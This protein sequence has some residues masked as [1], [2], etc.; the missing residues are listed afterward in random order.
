MKKL[1]AVLLVIL[2]ILMS[3]CGGNGD[4]GETGDEP[5]GVVSDYRQDMRAFVQ[6][7]SAYAK[8]IQ[9]NFVIIPQNGHELLTENGEETGIHAAEYLEAIDGVGREDLF[10]GYTDDNV[11]TPA[12]DR[13]YMLTFMNIA[14]VNGVEVM[15]TDYCSTPANML[16]SYNQCFDKGYI[17]FAADHRELDNIPEYPLDPYWIND[18][19]I[20]SLAHAWNFLYLLN[21]DSFSDRD[22]FLNE[23]RGTNYDIL[24]IDAFYGGME[25][26]TAN[27]VTSLKTKANG[28][29]R[30]VIAYMSIGEAENY[31]Y[32]WLSGWNT[33]PPSWLAE[34]N[35]NWPDNYKVR[36]WLK[37]WQDIIYGNDNSYLKKILDAGFDGVYLDIIDAYEFFEGFKK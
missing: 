34:E 19:D 21:T 9:A 30:L 22:D 15:V 25:A 35:P 32:Y 5:N 3:G 36:F 37:S 7:I 10:Y 20:A 13:N 11:A 12:A 23:L 16:V 6:G 28:G 33:T 14:E 17:S 27:E 2:A 18:S 24:L 29:A 26:L 4:N 1:L 31:R 8:D